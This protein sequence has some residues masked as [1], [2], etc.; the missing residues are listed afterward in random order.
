MRPLTEDEK[1]GRALA[2]S[3]GCSPW[4]YISLT[5]V[6]DQTELSLQF[7]SLTENKI[8]F[9]KDITL[10]SSDRLATIEIV[11]A[12]PHLPFG[13]PGVYAFEIVC[14]GEVIGS[15]RIVATLAGT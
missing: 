6:C 4:A 7:V 9:S 5:D 11:D 15:H 13:R 12:L 14:E 1:E 10:Y 2:S 8:L 3:A